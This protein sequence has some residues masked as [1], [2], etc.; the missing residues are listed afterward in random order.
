MRYSFFLESGISPLWGKNE[1]TKFNKA[2]SLF[3]FM[4]KATIYNILV[5]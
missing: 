1:L 4:I 3:I 2:C 5:N